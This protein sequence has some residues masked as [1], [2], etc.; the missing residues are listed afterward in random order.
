[1]TPEDRL[2]DT[3]ARHTA[4]VVAPPTGWHDLEHR[5]GEA[6]RSRR[7]RRLTGLGVLATA[8]AVVLLAVVRDDNS[9]DVRVA[10]SPPSTTPAV[11]ASTTTTPSAASVADPASVGGIY[12]DARA[13]EEDGAD[14]YRDPALA[15][16]AFATAYLGMPTPVLGAFTPAGTGGG[17]IALRP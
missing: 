12:P 1:M 15:A 10:T 8:V 5:S 6:L 17:R 3:L 14:S 11:D 9:R 7:R 4:T 13:F 2:R 16:R